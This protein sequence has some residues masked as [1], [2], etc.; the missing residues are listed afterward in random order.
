MLPPDTIPPYINNVFFSF[1]FLVL[2]FVCGLLGIINSKRIDGTGY[3]SGILGLIIIGLFLLELATNFLHYSFGYSLGYLM[4]YVGFAQLLIVFVPVIFGIIGVKNAK[5]ISGAS[6][7][8]GWAGLILGILY[9]AIFLFQAIGMY[10][11][12]GTHGY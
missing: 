11:Y 1:I 5:K 4:T 12:A 3:K 9:F 8:I 10:W 6:Q 2:T 7:I